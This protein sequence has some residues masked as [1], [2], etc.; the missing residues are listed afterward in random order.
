MLKSVLIFSIFIGVAC[1][2]HAQSGFAS[3][4]DTEFQIDTIGYIGFKSYFEYPSEQ[5]LRAF[6]SYTK[7]FAHTENRK[8]YYVIT[9]PPRDSAN[10]A[11]TLIG[12]AL[13]GGSTSEFVL[14]MDKSP[15]KKDPASYRKQLKVMLLE[16]KVDMYLA[17]YQDR[18]NELSKEAKKLSK[19]HQKAL[20]KGQIYEEENANR[21]SKLQGLEQQISVLRNNQL[22]L[23]SLLQKAKG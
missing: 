2:V 19:K 16:F 12:Q 8:S 11:I 10:V 14:G 3:I 22:N 6:W 4:T 18:I 9:I 21:L 1:N 15:F 5:V 7:S 17:A 23:L 20:K 13:R